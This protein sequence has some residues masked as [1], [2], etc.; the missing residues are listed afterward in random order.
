MASRAQSNRPGSVFAVDAL[1]KQVSGGPTRL[2]LENH[3]S[4]LMCFIV[5]HRLSLSSLNGRGLK[6]VNLV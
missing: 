5:V 3:M 2:S 6:S 1:T 4:T